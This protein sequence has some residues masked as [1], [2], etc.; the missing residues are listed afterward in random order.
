V[1]I[2]EAV[3]LDIPC[4]SAATAVR[5]HRQ[6]ALSPIGREHDDGATGASATTGIV[7]GA[8]VYGES[9]RSKGCSPSEAVGANE[10]DS[11]ACRTCTGLVVT[12]CIVPRSCS[13]ATTH[14]N[15]INGRGKRRS[16]FTARTQI[17][18]PGIAAKSATA[19]VGSTTGT[20]V[21]IIGCGVPIGST[22]TGI[23]WGTVSHAAIYAGRSAGIADARRGLQE[24]RTGFD[25]LRSSR[26]AFALCAVH[27]GH[28][29]RRAGIRCRGHPLIISV[30][31]GSAGQLHAS[32]APESVAID[33]NRSST[34]VKLA[35]NVQRKDSTR[36]AVP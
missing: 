26:H 28:T 21:L 7:Q 2:G 29:T 12:V 31:S 4:I 6:P 17:R 35:R 10:N 22:A 24:C 1:A 20:S 16:A 32:A 18:I 36:G 34:Q 23:A 15:A 19:T 11:A 30:R 14:S 27:P 8:V 3:G 5:L 13:A 9:I 25:P 33:I